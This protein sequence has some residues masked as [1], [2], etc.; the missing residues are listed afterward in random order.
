MFSFSLQ[1]LSQTFLILRRNEKDMI[2]NVYLSSIKVTFMLVRIKRN[3]NYFD[4]VSK[5][6]QISN[7]GSVSSPLC[8]P[9]PIFKYRIS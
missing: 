6:T 1:L 4:R 2:K 8:I 3:L 7:F 9:F 5:N